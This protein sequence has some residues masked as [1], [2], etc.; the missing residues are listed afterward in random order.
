[1]QPSQT[2][3]DPAE[4]A[5]GQLQPELQPPP[6][7]GSTNAAA[8]NSTSADESGMSAD[9]EQ[10]AGADSNDRAETNGS[11][12]G[13]DMQVEGKHAEHQQDQETTAGETCFAC[14]MKAIP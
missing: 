9:S 13:K 14:C 6:T 2:D 11:D 3:Q 10:E 1:M 8:A 7:E 4:W 12:H 5:E